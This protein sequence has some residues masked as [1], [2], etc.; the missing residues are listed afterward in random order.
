MNR[1]IELLKKKSPAQLILIWLPKRLRASPLPQRSP[2]DN[3][4]GGIEWEI[5]FLAYCNENTLLLQFYQ[6]PT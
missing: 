6:E 1:S 4:G 5:T 3:D 2:R